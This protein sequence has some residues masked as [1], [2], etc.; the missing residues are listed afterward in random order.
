MVGRYGDVVAIKKLRKSGKIDDIN[1]A[2][3]NTEFRHDS[4]Y[5][6]ACRRGHLSVVNFLLALDVHE[7]KKNDDGMTALMLACNGGHLEV[8]K[9]VCQKGAK[10]EHKDKLGRTALFIA[11]ERGYL[12]VVRYLVEARVKHDRYRVCLRAL[13]YLRAL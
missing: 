4:A 9:T 13:A 1:R 5:M 7:H 3:Y 11:A 10:K 6:H 12:D 8:V 2:A